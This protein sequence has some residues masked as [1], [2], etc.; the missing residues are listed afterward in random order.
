VPTRKAIQQQE[1]MPES[2]FVAQY[3]EQISSSELGDQLQQDTHML[4][5]QVREEEPKEEVEAEAEKEE[6]RN[7]GC[8]VKEC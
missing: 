7:I 4:L 6:G 1:K 3:T 8:G 2:T 5:D